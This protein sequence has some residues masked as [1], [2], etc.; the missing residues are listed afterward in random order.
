MRDGSP[1]YASPATSPGHV[2]VGFYSPAATLPPYPTPGLQDPPAPGD[3]RGPSAHHQR[4]P[5]PTTQYPQHWPPRSPSPGFARRLSPLQAQPR[6]SSSGFA[7]PGPFSP[8]QPPPRRPSLVFDGSPLQAS[9]GRSSFGF[10]GPG[11]ANGWHGAAPPSPLVIPRRQTPASGPLP[12]T[13]ASGPTARPSPALQSPA[14][15]D[16]QPRSSTDMAGRPA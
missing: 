13:F 3:D 2:P 15:N 6:R 8:Q 7:G 10:G 4:Q 5:S 12:R 14:F 16:P 11:L 9:P 1:P